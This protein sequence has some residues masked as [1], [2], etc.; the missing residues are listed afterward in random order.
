MQP[1]P[2]SVLI[3]RHQ[4]VLIYCSA[5]PVQKAEAYLLW[6]QCFNTLLLMPTLLE[7]IVATN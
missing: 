4:Y 3:P 7:F 6:S 1:K 5:T 2:K